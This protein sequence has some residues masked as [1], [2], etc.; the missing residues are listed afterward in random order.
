MQ[1]KSLGDVVLYEWKS[2]ANKLNESKVNKKE[3]QKNI[4]NSH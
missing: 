2:F 1:K 3:I 4:L